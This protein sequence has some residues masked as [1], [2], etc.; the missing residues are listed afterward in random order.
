M[1][2]IVVREWPSASASTGALW[3]SSPLAPK[4]AFSPAFMAPACLRAAPGPHRP[5]RTIQTSR[6]ST[7]ST[8]TTSSVSCTT[9]ISRPTRSERRAVSRLTPEIG[10][11]ARCRKGARVRDPERG[12]VPHSIRLVS[13][14][15]SSS[16]STHRAR[17]GSTPAL[18][19]GYPS[20]RPSPAYPAA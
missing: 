3:M 11:G 14:V 5:P 13:E 4:S 2:K 6:S 17:F 15:L 19:A 9:T 12:G 20:E 7:T 16:G 18:M 10:H 8:A 1:Q